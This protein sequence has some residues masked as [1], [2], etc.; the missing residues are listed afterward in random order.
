M[1]DRGRP[2]DVD[3]LV[4]GG[5]PAGLA[6]AEALARAGAGRVVVLEREHEP[7]GIPRHCHHTGYGVRDLGRVLTGPAYAARTTQA[8]DRRGRRGAHRRHGD[9]LGRTAGAGPDLAGRSGAGHGAR[10]RARDRVRGSDPAPP[11][12]VPGDRPAGVYTTGQLQQAVYLYRQPVGTRAVVVGAEHVSFSAAMTL[13]HADVRVAAMV[14]PYERQQSFAAFRVGATLRQGFP[15]LTGTP[16]ARLVGRRRLEAV[17]VRGA[18]GRVRSIPCDTVVFTGDW[19]PDHELA[20]GAGCALDRGS[21]GPA[22]DTGQRT[23]AAGV[24]AVGN[25][26]HP[27]TTADVAA[28]GGRAVAAAVL[29]RL[30]GE[31][32]AA[33]V[34]VEVTAPLRWAAPSRVVPGEPPP[35]GRFV[36]WSDAFVRA[37]V[38]RV[39]QD[40]RVLARSRVL[41]GLVPQRPAWLGGGWT[42]EVDP[43]GG[44]VTLAVG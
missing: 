3:V 35:R 4:V 38:V 17:E 1:S 13:A 25:L 41:P 43:A 19:I 39:E 31:P 12:W 24:F 40:G 20:V 14:T 5:G 10:G 23:T 27:V 22:V 2:R 7:G 29:A 16:V 9:R 34:A 30:A 37:P 15:L 6:A 44:A 42:Q 33:G 28:L 18:D 11:A 8:A 36:L 26:W 32:A 21:L